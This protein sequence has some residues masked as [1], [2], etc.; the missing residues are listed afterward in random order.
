MS[1]NVGNNNN[2]NDDKGLHLN[3]SVNW[4]EEKGKFICKFAVLHVA[5]NDEVYFNKNTLVA[6]IIKINENLSNMHPKAVE[7]FSRKLG[8][9]G[10]FH[11]ALMFKNTTEEERVR[12]TGYISRNVERGISYAVKI[13][14]LCSSKG[15]N[16]FFADEKLPDFYENMKDSDKEFFGAVVDGYVAQRRAERAAKIEESERNSIE[17][18][19]LK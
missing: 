2:R 16:E 12:A 19:H 9:A 13:G 14:A 8:E 6:S 18:E 7:K 3:E 1:F 5:R 15:D 10:L 11:P 17:I 4:L